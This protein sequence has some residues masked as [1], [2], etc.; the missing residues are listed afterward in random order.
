[1]FSEF[2]VSTEGG[3]PDGVVAGPDGKLW[4]TDHVGNK[5]GKLTLG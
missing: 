4:F 1:V 5:I 3:G 2:R